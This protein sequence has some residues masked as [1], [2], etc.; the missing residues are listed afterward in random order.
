MLC[1]IAYASSTEY[2]DF[3]KPIIVSTKNNI[4]TV[5]LPGNA[6]TGYT[7]VLKDDYNREMIRP[8]KYHYHVNN[9]KL[10]GSSGQFQFTFRVLPEAFTVPKML[11]PLHFAYLRPWDAAGQVDKTIDIQVITSAQPEEKVKTL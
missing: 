2:S 8:I 11:Q 10:M 9:E 7:W 1:G 5:N 4:F 6:T 3:S